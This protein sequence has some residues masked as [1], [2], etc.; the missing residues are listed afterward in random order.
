[1]TDQ[2]GLP[3]YVDE[4]RSTITAP[5]ERVWEA[6]RQ[7]VDTSLTNDK[8]NP[9]LRL[10]GTEP[11]AGFAVSHEVPGTRLD[12]SGRHRFSRYLLSFE[13]ADADGATDVIARTYADF[14]GARG[15][16]Y[17]TLVIGT[18]FHVLA[19]RAMLHSIRTSTTQTH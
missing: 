13:L 1:M 16:V 3:S 12:L 10:L 18:R 15:F 11:R 7:Y 9:L 6:L 8:A 14:P 4:H 2:D 19:V 5:R 17:R